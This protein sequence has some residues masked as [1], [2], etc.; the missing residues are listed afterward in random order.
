MGKGR[1]STMRFITIV[2]VSPLDAGQGGE[3]LIAE[4]LVGG[5]VGGGDADQVVGVSEEPFGVA[6]LG[7]LRQAPLEVRDRRCV[8]P[9]H[10]HEYQNLEAE[11]DRGGINEGPIAADRSRT[12]QLAQ[13]SVA[14]RH[15]EPGPLRQ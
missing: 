2:E 14:R 5:E 13:P 9:L 15:A 10:H 7:N 1:S 12:L 3:L 11:P 6:H 8:L 4:V